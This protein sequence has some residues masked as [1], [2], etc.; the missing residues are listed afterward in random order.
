M[1]QFVQI[2]N[3]KKSKIENDSNWLDITNMN[4]VHTNSVNNETQ[5]QRVAYVTVSK[6]GSSHD[7]TQPSTAHEPSRNTYLRGINN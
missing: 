5:T 2:K 6:G 7:A 1:N 4:S 3:R